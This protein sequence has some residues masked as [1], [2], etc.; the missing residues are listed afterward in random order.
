MAKKM[1]VFAGKLPSL[2]VIPRSL[3]DLLKLWAPIMGRVISNDNP[4]DV[5]ALTPLTTTTPDV[6]NYPYH[7]GT[8]P[9]ASKARKI[10]EYVTHALSGDPDDDENHGKLTIG[11]IEIQLDKKKTVSSREI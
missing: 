7:F 9:F 1:K 4:L 3:E 2:P 8:G 6:P 5:A 10:G 11:D